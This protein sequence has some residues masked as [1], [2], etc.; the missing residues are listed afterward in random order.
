MPE[1]RLDTYTKLLIHFD[2]AD[3]D[4]S[5]QTAATGQTVSLEGDAQLDTAYRKFGSASL[6]GT[7][8]GYAT[9]PDSDDWYFAANPFTIDFWVYLTASTSQQGLCGQYVDANNYWAL[10]YGI[11]A[12]WFDVV[13][14]GVTKAS[15]LCTFIAA[16]NLNAWHHIEVMRN[17]ENIR[18]S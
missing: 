18:F 12:L 1:M 5:D 17:G 16:S 6:Q 11:N 10:Y 2:G 4:T 13:V 9:V 15:H 3:G 7:G 8:G 14:G